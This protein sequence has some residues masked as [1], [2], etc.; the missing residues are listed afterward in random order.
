[1]NITEWKT[2]DG[3]QVCSLIVAFIL[4]GFLYELITGSSRV[5]SISKKYFGFLL[6]CKKNVLIPENIK[7]LRKKLA[8][9]R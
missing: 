9:E 7:S 2:K 1:V 6:I 8:R 3:F 5:F 4:N